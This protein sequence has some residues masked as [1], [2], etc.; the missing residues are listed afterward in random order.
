MNSSLIAELAEGINYYAVNTTYSVFSSNADAYPNAASFTTTIDGPGMITAVSA[1]NAVPEPEA[2]AIF[3][4]GLGLMGYIVKR[5]KP[6]TA[7]T[8]SL[9]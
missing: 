3:L 6:T 7:K 5:R 2:F 4:T 1:A 9:S 8:D